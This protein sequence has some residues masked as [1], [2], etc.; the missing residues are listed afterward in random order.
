MPEPYLERLVVEN[1]GCIQ[2]AEFRL[3]R[4]H[5][6]IGPN[7]CGKSTVL[8]ALWTLGGKRLLGGVV[9]TGWSGKGKVE[10]QRIK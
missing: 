7:D 8:Q 9:L 6:L 10:I 4:L 5:A 1:Y 3:S 2:K